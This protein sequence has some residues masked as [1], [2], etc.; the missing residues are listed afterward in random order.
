[1][2]KPVLGATTAVQ[3]GFP[4]GQMAKKVTVKCHLQEFTRLHGGNL[5]FTVTLAPEQEFL[6]TTCK[7]PIALHQHQVM[8]LSSFLHVLHS[9]CQTSPLR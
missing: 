3:G 8:L 2:V 9:P 7:V 1:M 6:P 4:Q 5:A